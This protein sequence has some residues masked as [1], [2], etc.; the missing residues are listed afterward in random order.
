MPGVLFCETTCEVRQ[1][2][3]LK[4]IEFT[5]RLTHQDYYCCGSNS[6]TITLGPPSLLLLSVLPFLSET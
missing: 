3:S 2:A 1:Y 6:G 5:S 4:A